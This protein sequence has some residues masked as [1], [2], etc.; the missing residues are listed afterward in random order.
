[1]KPDI[2]ASVIVGKV[3][4]G[5]WSD[6]L[7]IEVEQDPDETVHYALVLTNH[8]DNWKDQGKR[9]KIRLEK[10]QMIQLCRNMLMYLEDGIIP[11]LEDT[12]FDPVEREVE[13]S[14]KPAGD[15]LQEKID[16]MVSDNNNKEDDKNA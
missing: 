6:K 12:K 16:K 11:P 1:M 14:I 8:N 13:S 7:S 10:D 4:H 3:R 15:L 5:T 9:K 2:I